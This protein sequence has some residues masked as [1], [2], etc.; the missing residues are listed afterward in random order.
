MKTFLEISA[1]YVRTLNI[2]VFP[3][4]TNLLLKNISSVVIG[5]INFFEYDVGTSSVQLMRNA[6]EFLESFNHVK[7]IHIERHCFEVCIDAL[8]SLIYLCTPGVEKLR[9]H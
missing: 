6:S 8:V 1:P 2:T 4:R 3:H 5:V 9:T 7:R